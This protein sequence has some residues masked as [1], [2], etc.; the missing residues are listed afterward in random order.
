MRIYSLQKMSNL[1][2]KKS[3]FKI[4]SKHL[5]VFNNVLSGVVSVI[6]GHSGLS[7]IFLHRHWNCKWGMKKLICSGYMFLKIKVCMHEPSTDCIN[8]EVFKLTFN[9]FDLNFKIRKKDEDH[10]NVIKSKS[11]W[12]CQRV[13][14]WVIQKK[15][16]G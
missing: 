15:H 11:T 2:R 7:W 13:L 5:W 14:N 6:A 12:N 1:K 8:F 10:Q 16:F 4:F 9:V 3:N